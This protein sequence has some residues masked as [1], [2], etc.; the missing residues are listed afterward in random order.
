[1]VIGALILLQPVGV[2][3]GHYAIGKRDK[4]RLALRCPSVVRSKRNRKEVSEH[5]KICCEFCVLARRN[6][7]GNFCVI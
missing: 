1:M 2:V 3:N 7:E 5:K 6:E 4:S